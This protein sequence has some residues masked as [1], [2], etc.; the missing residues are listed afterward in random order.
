MRKGSYSE[1]LVRL[2]AAMSMKKFDA[3]RAMLGASRRK[4][5][6]RRQRVES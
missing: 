3:P 5:Y 4:E 2:V 1:E 6:L